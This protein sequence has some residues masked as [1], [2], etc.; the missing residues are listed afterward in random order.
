MSYFSTA[1]TLYSG[2][3]MGEHAEQSALEEL[4]N[5][6]RATLP[7]QTQSVEGRISYVS[8]ISSFEYG[9][10]TKGMVQNYIL[11]DEV[12][13]RNMQEIQTYRITAWNA[14]VL[15]HL[16]EKGNYYRISNI[17]WRKNSWNRLPEH[18]CSFDIHLKKSSSIDH[19]LV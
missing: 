1:S 11:T 3:Q 13:Q 8:P 5:S 19:I 10:G 14:Q 7:P 15:N 6:A 17:A 16:L 4:L 2:A 18:Q 12:A 9:D